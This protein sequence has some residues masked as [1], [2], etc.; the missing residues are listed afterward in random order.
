MLSIESSQI[1]D[2]PSFGSGLNT[3]F[4]LGVGKVGQKVIM[5]LDVDRVLTAKE[6]DAV[7]DMGK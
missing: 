5:M 7:N 2:T 3:E 6:M 1:E 4:I